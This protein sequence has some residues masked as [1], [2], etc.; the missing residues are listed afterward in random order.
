[1][2]AAPPNSDTR[3]SPIM[4]ESPLTADN[5]FQR[6]PVWDNIGRVLITPYVLWK[7]SPGSACEGT[8]V[9]DD[10][11]NRSQGNNR[12]VLVLISYHCID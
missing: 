11:P 6:L 4:L 7:Q 8:F 10:N 3:T 12:L 2:A 5:L 9:A 1:M